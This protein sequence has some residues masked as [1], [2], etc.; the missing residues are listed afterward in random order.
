M[1][2][3]LVL[4]N[5][6]L[7][8]GLNNYSEVHDFYFPY[9]GLENHAAGHKMRHKIGVWVDDE[10]SWLDDGTW[11]FLHDYPHR[12]LIGH[13]RAFNGGLGIVLEIDS[14][15]DAGQNAFVRHIHVIN[16]R[17]KARVIK[18][19][20][21]QV[22]AISENLRGDTVQYLPG[23]PAILHYKGH[24]VFMVTGEDADGQ[25]FDEFSTGLYKDEEHEGT[26]KD[27]EDGEL[28]GNYVE[29]GN[30]DSV[31]GFTIHC[32][33]LDSARVY[34]WIAAGKSYKE[35]LQILNRVKR[36][37]PEQR[38]MVTN[39]WWRKWLEPAEKSIVHLP[40][41]DQALFRK[42]LMLVK[43]HIDK[44]GAV[45]ASTDTSMLNYWRDAYAYCWARDASF[46][47]WP[48][49]RLGYK[50]EIT[51]FFDFCRRVIHP[52][53]YLQ[54]KYQADGAMGS[55]W[56]PFVYDNMTIPPI[57]ED[58]TASVLFLIGQ[59][60]RM[61]P[62]D[63]SFKEIYAELVKP[64]ADFMAMY[65][66]NE[67]K[68]PKPSYDLW[69]EKYLTTTYT[70][71]IVYAA[72]ITATHL[73]DRAHQDEDAVRWQ[74]VAEEIKK[75]ASVHLFDDS[76]GYFY[77]GVIRKEHSL[78]WSET[79]DLSSFYGAFM[80]GLFDADSH[81]M[82]TA[83]KTIKTTFSVGEEEAQG[84][85]RYEHDQYNIVDPASLGNPWFITTLWVAQY[86]IEMNQTAKA[87]RYLNWVA[88]K[89]MT[90]GVIAEQLNPYTNSFLSVSVA[91]LA[92]SQAELLNTY[93]DV[94]GGPVQP[95][96]I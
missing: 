47:L 31:I 62:N 58:E 3:P 34:Y 60:F 41:D 39:E 94:M 11:E 89:A 96:G 64:M 74:T 36:E 85:P 32:D 21:H 93:L 86:Y 51:N 17:D 50:E 20:M 49:L 61:Y 52:D 92:W 69:E 8:V 54:H 76:R 65:I 9:V 95:E 68:L 40:K 73:A 82:K 46:V 44:R 43:S 66:D 42:S 6:E 19:Y 77:K 91:P 90:S 70:S 53:G 26:Y 24:R 13:T 75:A 27:A 23:K 18:L 55:S 5:G 1:A 38:L 37:G 15:V 71:A 83:F 35:C 30:V 87:K 29:H 48:L 22:F 63:P 67:T 81:E 12:S 2:R 10:F 57:Q 88:D 84:I 56:H 16:S 33:A 79:V 59:Y 78:E 25:Q 45:I 28:S 80:F 7:H 4:S 72:L 14:Y